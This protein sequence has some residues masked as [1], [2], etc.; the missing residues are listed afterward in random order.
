MRSEA[1]ELLLKFNFVILSRTV[2]TIFYNI[3]L[4]YR[5]GILERLKME[6]NWDWCI[7][8]H[9]L[10]NQKLSYILVFVYL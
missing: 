5:S 1:K 3:S 10:L 9:D 8:F 6:E 7:H 2:T 4:F